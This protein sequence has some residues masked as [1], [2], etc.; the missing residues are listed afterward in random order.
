[1]LIGWD[2]VTVDSANQRLYLTRTTHTIAA[3]DDADGIIYDPASDRVLVSQSS[4]C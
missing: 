2:Y 4:I 1:M 3:A